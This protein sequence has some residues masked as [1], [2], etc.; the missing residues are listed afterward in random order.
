[1]IEWLDLLDQSAY[2][3]SPVHQPLDPFNVEF[4]ED[5]LSGVSLTSFDQDYEVPEHLL[6]YGPQAVQE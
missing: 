6:P 1:M 4:V 2:D 5:A 3:D